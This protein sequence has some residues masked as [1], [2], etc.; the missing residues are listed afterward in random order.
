MSKT[1]KTKITAEPGKQEILI[2]RELDAPIELVWKAWTEEESM[3]KW[4]GP[5]NFTAPKI[6]IDFRVGG[7]YTLCM[8]GAGMDG[9]VR[10]GYNIGEYVQIIPMEKITSTMSFANEH[11]KLIMPSEF[12]LPGEWP[13][14]VILIVT[15]G[16][17]KGKRTKVMVNE[18]GIP[19]VIGEMAA[20]GWAQQFDK[21][22]KLLNKEI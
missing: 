7:R 20:E 9:V 12:G 16:E 6:E 19:G 8:R 11:G 15:F 13:S 21:F 10:D 17:L 4:W 3:K 14:V 22:D 18:I 5:T 2:T 1:N